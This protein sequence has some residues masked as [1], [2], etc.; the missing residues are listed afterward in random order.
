[1]IGSKNNAGG[2]TLVF[3]ILRLGVWG[4]LA[5]QVGG[6][7]GGEASG[8]VVNS[9]RGTGLA[10]GLGVVASGVGVLLGLANALGA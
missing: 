9:L 1:M 6:G 8:W 3:H 5:T 7:G 2:K 10:G 4:A